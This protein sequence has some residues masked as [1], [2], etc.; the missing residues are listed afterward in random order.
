MTFTELSESQ[1]EQ[2]SE[3]QGQWYLSTML[4]EETKGAA[5]MMAKYGASDAE[6]GKMIRH[7]MHDYEKENA[8]LTIHTVSHSSY[9]GSFGVMV[10]VPHEHWYDLLTEQ[11]T[12][13][14]WGEKESHVRPYGV[15][16]DLGIL[17]LV[18]P[19]IEARGLSNT[20]LP[21]SFRSQV[22][23][24]VEQSSR[25]QHDANIDGHS[26]EFTQ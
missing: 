4:P 10:L 14:A 19:E 16:D 22:E 13:M 20:V 23:Q 5:Q 17:E 18:V 25:F 9:A 7:H 2:M 3:S 12:D 1:F 24:A 15:P 8:G 26:V 6:I 11:I 21:E